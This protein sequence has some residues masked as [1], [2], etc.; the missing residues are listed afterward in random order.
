M[1]ELLMIILDRVHTGMIGVRNNASADARQWR[2]W[3]SD[4]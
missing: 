3:D 2:Y 1:L 4:S